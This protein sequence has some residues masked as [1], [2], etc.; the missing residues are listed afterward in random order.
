MISLVLR[1]LSVQRMQPYEHTPSQRSSH[2]TES[3]RP[4]IFEEVNFMKLMKNAWSRMTTLY[5]HGGA[6]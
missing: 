6:C 2:E 4:Q 5:V 3:S 1:Y